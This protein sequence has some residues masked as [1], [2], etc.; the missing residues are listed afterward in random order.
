MV[1]DR[2]YHHLLVLLLVIL[3]SLHA[4]S[5]FKSRPARLALDWSSLTGLLVLSERVQHRASGVRRRCAEDYTSRGGRPSR[6]EGEGCEESRS[7]CGVVRTFVLPDGSTI[8]LNSPTVVIKVQ[9]VTHM[10]R[11]GEAEHCLPPCVTQVHSQAL[12]PHFPSKAR[13]VRPQ[14]NLVQPGGR[15]LTACLLLLR[16]IV[17]AY[18]PA[19][20]PRYGAPRCIETPRRM[21][22]GPGE[23]HGG[24]RSSVPEGKCRGRLWC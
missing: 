4:H 20:P 5:L 1:V 21:V 6:C 16:G 18:C 13:R 22:I 12:L 11:V 3:L 24:L 10:G 19:R 7:L 15:T 17:R 23:V 2:W 14:T 9:L 8:W